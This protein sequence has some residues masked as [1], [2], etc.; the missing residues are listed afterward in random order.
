MCSFL[1][2]NKSRHFILLT[3]VKVINVVTITTK[4]FRDSYGLEINLTE[5]TE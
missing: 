1:L 4:L 2:Q 3:L 5:H